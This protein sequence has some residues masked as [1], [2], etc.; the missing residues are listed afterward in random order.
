MRVSVIEAL[1]DKMAR[2]ELDEELGSST[3]VLED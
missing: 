3:P 1:V 2:A